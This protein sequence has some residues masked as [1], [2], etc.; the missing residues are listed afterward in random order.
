LNINY[1]IEADQSLQSIRDYITDNNP[2]AADKVIARILQSISILELFPLIGRKGRVD[3]T[4]ELIIPT[5][6]Y[7]VIYKIISETDIDIL[8]IFHTSRK[9]P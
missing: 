2:T 3:E 8:L 1:T 5:L 6:P 7:I 4:R 9:Y